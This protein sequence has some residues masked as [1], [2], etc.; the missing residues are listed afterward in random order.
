MNDVVSR[1]SF[2][3]FLITSK[4]TDPFDRSNSFDDNGRCGITWILTILNDDLLTN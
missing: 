1:T 3:L 2:D 4:I